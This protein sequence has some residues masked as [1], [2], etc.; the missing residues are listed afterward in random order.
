MDVDL[1]KEEEFNINN[2]EFQFRKNETIEGKAL[3][4]SP[5]Y[6]KQIKWQDIQVQSRKLLDVF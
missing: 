1:Q 6:I 3:I 4:H 5:L 2:K